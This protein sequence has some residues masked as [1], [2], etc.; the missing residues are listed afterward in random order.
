MYRRT[1]VLV[2]FRCTPAECSP[3]MELGRR[4]FGARKV[5]LAHRE[6]SEVVQGKT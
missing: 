5:G 1:I 6:G 3:L 4:G 2:T